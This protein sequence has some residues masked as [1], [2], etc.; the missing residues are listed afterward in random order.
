M[1]KYLAL[2][3]LASTALMYSCGTEE[4]TFKAPSVSAPA[5]QEVEAGSTVEVTFSFEAEAGFA[6]SSV[7][8]ENGV[9]TVSADATVGATSGTITVAFTAGT[10]GGAG[11]AT[12][13]VTDTE[14]EM[15]EA[16]AVFTVVEEITTFTVS[17]NISADATWETGKTYILAG[18]ISVTNNATLTIQPG[19]VVKGQAGTGANA[20]ALVVARGSKL[21][22][23]GTATMPIIFTSIADEL[24]PADIAAG[25]FES[26]NLEPN[27]AGLW[28]GVIVL[29]RAPI[30]VANDAPEAAIEGIP[31]TDTN[32]L[33]GGS[34]AD[35]NSGTISYISIRH[36]GANIGEGNE[37]NGLTL[38]GVGNGTTIMGVEV[39]SNA[40]DGIEFF[41]G[42]VN[43]SNVMIWNS[44]D[45]A[46]DTDQDYQ[47]TVT[48]F[49]IITP[50]GGSGFELDGPEGTA[51]VNG[52]NGFHTFDNGV[53]YAGGDIAVTVDWD[54][55]T[56][57]AVKNVYFFGFT[58][59]YL[60]GT[61]N[62][63]ESFGGDGSGTSSGWEMTLPAGSD[64]TA[65]FG[66]GAAAI[67]TEVTTRTKGPAASSFAWTWASKS[68]K[69]TEIGL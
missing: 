1:K 38:G 39:V 13:V 28:G 42:V 8:G 36:G 2:I 24:S 20:T 25:N 41:G 10:N 15:D 53:V 54:G 58:E 55:S 46:L 37:I 6:S 26:P 31:T 16:T 29:G 11:S 57:A 19:V 51:K 48:D 59:A 69:L 17:E 43:V 35:D 66:A 21:M 62:K 63:I 64:L 9:A 60:T 18:R 27:I 23:E 49:V 4:E 34:A 68:G 32:G 56:N 30:S 3:T 67:T 50:I 14:G 45:D 47:G 61:A 22:A 12:L 44:N 52:A 40:D 7:S 33:Y 65:A 5:T